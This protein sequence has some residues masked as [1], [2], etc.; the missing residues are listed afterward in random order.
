M[1]DEFIEWEKLIKTAFLIGI[2]PN[3]LW[4]LTPWELNSILATEN[5][6]IAKQDLEK[7]KQQFPDQKV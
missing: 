5:P 4:K 1:K 3:E 6:A 7:L 2:K